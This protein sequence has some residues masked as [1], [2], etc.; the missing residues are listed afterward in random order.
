MA[1]DPDTPDAAQEPLQRR[2]ATILAADV[3]GYSRMMG[4]NEEATV[5][6]LRRHRAI[7]DALL[8]QHHGRV[9][10]TAGD[11]ILAEFPSAVEAVRCA[12]EIQAAIQTRNDQIESGQ[13]MWFRMG[14]NLGDV[15]V[16]GGDLLGE[17]VNVAAR[18]QTVA[19]PGGICISGSVYDQIQNK[20]SLQFRTLG[21]QQFKNIARPVRTFSITHGES[22]ALP[23]SARKPAMSVGA[24]GIA[25]VVIV[26]IAAA[27]FWFY[28]E[29]DAREREKAAMAA[30]IV[31]AKKSAGDFQQQ[32]ADEIRR[33]T[34]EV[35]KAETTKALAEVAKSNAAPPPP[36]PAPPPKV[37]AV[38]APRDTGK[39]PATAAPSKSV[40]EHPRA[41]PEAAGTMTADVAT[42]ARSAIDGDYRGQ[43]CNLPQDPVRRTCWKVP[44]H[45]RNGEADAAWTSRATGREA[46][47]H[48]MFAG[49][50]S[51]RV[52][53]D[54]WKAVAGTPMSGAM[55]GSAANDHIDVEGRWS[56][57]AHVDGHWERAP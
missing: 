18:L 23:A 47:M 55:N 42:A 19:D 15:V 13:K 6:L 1:S 17:G 50:G 52:T 30:Q 51:V 46:H 40:A 9:F 31:D 32:L 20:L 14:I 56:N 21:D 53:L 39:A 27:G 28:R 11:M 43:M 22:G 54:G 3:A 41:A 25:A 44:L 12:T 37:A 36:P 48:A 10:N 24:L 26:A 7:F 4:E 38:Q 49:D 5:Q 35:I 57:G 34:E 45:V 2:L 16:Q 8:A 29:Q 33:S